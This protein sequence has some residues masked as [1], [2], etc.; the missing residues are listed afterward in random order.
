VCVCMRVCVRV[1]K[2]DVDMT[3]SVE[4]IY[5]TL[6]HTD[7]RILKHSRT[8]PRC[9]MSSLRTFASVGMASLCSET[10]AVGSVW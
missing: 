10:W 3:A 2:K 4:T 6:C 5:Y 7:P 1:C 8:Y 9:D